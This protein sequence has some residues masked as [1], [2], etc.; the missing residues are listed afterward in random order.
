MIRYRLIFVLLAAL[1]GALAASA[2]TVVPPDF[3]QLVQSSDYVIRGRVKSLRNEIRMRDG[4]ELPFTQVAIEVKEVIAGA[5]PAAVV[6]TMLGGRT[7]DGG[8]LTI[9]GVPQFT[10]GDEDVLFVRGNGTNFHPLNAVMHGRYPVKFDKKLN[11]EY[12]ARA[13]G[14]PLLATAEVALPLVDS[15]L[16][17]ELRRSLRADDALT[18]REFAQSIRTARA[19]RTTGGRTDVK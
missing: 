15:K 4:R 7:S 14:Q 18:P 13:N 6:L 17:R 2:T 3:D 19:T 10:V 12:I 11:R 1:A 8:Q 5:P 16:V 9:E